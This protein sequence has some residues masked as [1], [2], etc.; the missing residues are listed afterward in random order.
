[1]EHCNN[2]KVSDNPD[3]AA[4]KNW[5]IYGILYLIALNGAALSKPEASTSDG[6]GV[7]YGNDRLAVVGLGPGVDFCVRTKRGSVSHA[8][9]TYDVEK[10]STAIALWYVTRKRR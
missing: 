5:G 8:F 6:S 2:S 7:T 4:V 9:F 10:E 1:V 3:V